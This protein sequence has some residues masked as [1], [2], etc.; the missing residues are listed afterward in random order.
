MIDDTA[1]GVDAASSGARVDAQPVDAVATCRTVGIEEAFGTAVGRG[2]D[3][4]GETRALGSAGRGP[5]HRL[6][7]ARMRCAR[8]G[9]QGSQSGDFSYRT[10]YGGYS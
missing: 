2:T 10:G 1:L 5:T 6:R 7:T 3:G 4:A 9:R 8:M